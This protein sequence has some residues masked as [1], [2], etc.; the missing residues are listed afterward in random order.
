MVSI[1]IQGSVGV[2][3]GNFIPLNHQWLC[4]EHNL[5]GQYIYLLNIFIRSIYLF[6][7]YIYVMNIFIC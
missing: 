5:L 6:G 4:R 1:R 7:Q 2:Y 3:G